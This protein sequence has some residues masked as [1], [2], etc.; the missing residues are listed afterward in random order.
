MRAT[1]SLISDL[2]TGAKLIFQNC[3][4]PVTCPDEVV[5]FQS[6]CSTVPE[7]TS[8]VAGDAAP[9]GGAGASVA[10]ACNSRPYSTTGGDAMK[11][12]NVTIGRRAAVKPERRESTLAFW[13]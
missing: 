13:L 8:G 4:I 7:A 9:Y 2:I 3:G 12:A 6:S 1:E 5:R 10:G 11:A